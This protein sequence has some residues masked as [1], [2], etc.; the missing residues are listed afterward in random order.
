MR[1]LAALAL[2]LAAGCSDPTPP[3]SD[4]AAGDNGNVPVCAPRP[5]VTLPVPAR[6]SLSYLCS[7]DS[8][9]SRCRP[10]EAS[11]GGVLVAQERGDAGVDPPTPRFTC[12]PCGLECPSGQHC[13]NI[14]YER[15]S[16]VVPGWTCRDGAPPATDAGTVACEVTGNIASA[17]RQPDG[18][19]SY[20]CVTG[21][22]G[23]AT[24][25]GAGACATRVDSDQRCGNCASMCTTSTG[26]H[27]VYGVRRAAPQLGMVWHCERPDAG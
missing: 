26:A 15:D 1:H 19:C 21:P 14:A 2:L 8:F 24:C 18:T 20:R 16:V 4:G 23:Y 25:D 27:C 10:S 11:P 17:T 6:A 13:E 7:L 12:G 22:I 9:W 5:S 3:L